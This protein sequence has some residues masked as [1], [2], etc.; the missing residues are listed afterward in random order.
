MELLGKPDSKTPRKIG[1]SRRVGP[2]MR[3]VESLIL[4]DREYHKPAQL[5]DHFRPHIITSGITPE[6]FLDHGPGSSSEYL[7]AS[8]V[9]PKLKILALEPS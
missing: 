9:W 2:N 8:M 1:R 3:Q 5:Y 4:D 7:E 6:W